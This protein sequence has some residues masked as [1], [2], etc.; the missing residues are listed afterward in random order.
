V[1]EL[2]HLEFDVFRNVDKRV[3][4]ELIKVSTSLDCTIVL[5]LNLVPRFFFHVLRFLATRLVLVIK[6]SHELGSISGTELFAEHA[7]ER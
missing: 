2:V 6:D 4:Q 3:V 5:V 7:L 1:R